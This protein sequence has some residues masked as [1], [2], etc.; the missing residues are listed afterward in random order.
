LKLVGLGIGGMLL[1]KG[2]G[3]V[4]PYVEANNGCGTGMAKKTEEGNWLIC[5]TGEWQMYKPF[6]GV[7]AKEDGT[8]WQMLPEDFALVTDMPGR[9][10]KWLSPNEVPDYFISPLG[11]DNVRWAMWS[12]PN[13]QGLV[14]FTPTPGSLGK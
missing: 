13:G 3:F 2:D 12:N 8:E 1:L 11:V 6:D 10:T 4:G 7:V 5:D 9:I 14:G